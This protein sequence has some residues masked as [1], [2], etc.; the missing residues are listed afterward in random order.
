[1]PFTWWYISSV[2]TLSCPAPNPTFF[3]PLFPRLYSRAGRLRLNLG[4]IR[5]L[6]T[7]KCYS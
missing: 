1:M 3:K 5:P 4:V 2:S 6:S 7:E